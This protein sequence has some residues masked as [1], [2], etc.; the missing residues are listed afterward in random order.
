MAIAKVVHKWERVVPVRFARAP[1]VTDPTVDSGTYDANAPEPDDR[2][3]LPHGTVG[4]AILPI[5]LD[6]SIAD[7]NARPESRVRLIRMDME[8]AG[9]LFVSSS[10][11]GVVRVTLPATPADPLPSQRFMMI[12]MRAVRGGTA[13]L[14]IHFGSAN[15]PIIHQMQVVVNPL[16][17]VR[18][19]AH[20]PT[21]NGP[22]FI[23]PA[24]GAPIPAQGTRTNASIQTLI[25]DTNTMYFPY[26]IRFNLDAAIDRA[27]VF[28]GFQNQGMIDDLS[29][30]FNRMTTANVGPGGN[31]GAGRV[32]R[33]INAFF[34]PQIANPT[35]AV[36]ANQTPINVV[37]GVANSAIRNRATYGL[38][39]ADWATAAQTTA[40]EIGHLLNLVNDVDN[41]P[42]TQFVHINTR[43]DPAS[44]GTGRVVRF[45]T[46]SRRRLMWAFTT[47]NLGNSVQ[48][49]NRSLH[50][51]AFRNDVGYGADT[52]G[53]MLAV[54]Q[55]N[56]DATDLEMAEVR[57]TAGRL[58]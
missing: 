52:V 15:G 28:N 33:A 27:M 46:I 55:L 54:K 57:R 6:E 44:P 4:G 19:V 31:V 38:F 8:D 41:P 35:A 18:V 42:A 23:D 56:N 37:A 49:P 3:F 30:E 7:V 40:H 29:N 36:A 34:V 24:T 32:A 17:A 53:A 21:I 39:V 25:N 50:N 47:I 5:G 14:R 58:P 48:E 1:H 13:L 43:N 9:Q 22:A 51:L 20:V 16:I 11:P 2:G 26:G 12:K 10:N 45:D